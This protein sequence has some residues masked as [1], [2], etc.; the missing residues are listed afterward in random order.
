MHMRFLI[1]FFFCDG[2]IFTLAASLSHYG[3][4]VRAI[5]GRENCIQVKA[6][7]E[8]PTLSKL[9]LS[10]DTRCQAHLLILRAH[11]I[12]NARKQSKLGLHKQSKLGFRAWPQGELQVLIRTGHYGVVTG[13]KSSGRTKPGREEAPLPAAHKHMQVIL[14][15]AASPRPASARRSLHEALQLSQLEKPA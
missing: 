3:M 7:R 12:L 8:A 2:K 1:Y 10:Q 14:P 5:K 9:E 4:R 15:G 6:P 13:L 11:K